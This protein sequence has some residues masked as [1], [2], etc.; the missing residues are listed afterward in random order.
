MDKG[1]PSI[2]NMNVDTGFLGDRRAI[3]YTHDNNEDVFI[4]YNGTEPTNASDLLADGYILTGNESR[5]ERFQYAER[6]YNDVKNKCPHYFAL[7]HNQKPRAASAIEPPTQSR[8]DV[9]PTAFARDRRAA[10]QRV[11]G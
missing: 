8:V 7:T 9:A 2:P 1:A 5:S 11:L 3:V 10:G 4:T 6:L